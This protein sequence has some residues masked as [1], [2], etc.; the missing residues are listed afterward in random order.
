MNVSIGQIVYVKIEY[1][2]NIKKTTFE[3][4]IVVRISKTMIYT[5]NIK[6]G[7][8]FRFNK[9]TLKRVSPILLGESVCLQI[10]EGEN[11]EVAQLRNSIKIALNHMTIDELKSVEKYIRSILNR[12]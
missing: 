10:I 1:M 11:D 3:K 5:H 9:R 8:V 12:K 2:G 6:G 4:H 7:K